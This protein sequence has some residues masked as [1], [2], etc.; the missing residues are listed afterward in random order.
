M[1]GAERNI[2]TM[3]DRWSI[4]RYC[5]RYAVSSKLTSSRGLTLP[6]VLIENIYRNTRHCCRRRVEL[7]IG[8]TRNC[9]RSAVRFIVVVGRCLLSVWS[10]CAFLSRSLIVVCVHAFIAY[11]FSVIVVIVILFYYNPFY[12]LD[13]FICPNIDFSS[14]PFATN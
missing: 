6:I 13:V 14:V 2:A 8:F 9:Q 4:Y 3:S 7:Q 10:G 5:T 12:I 1:S 11:L